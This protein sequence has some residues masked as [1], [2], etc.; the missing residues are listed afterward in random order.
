MAAMKDEGPRHAVAVG[1]RVFLRPPEEADRDAFRRLIAESQ[2]FLAPW[3]PKAATD[4]G[5]DHRFE[6]L[7][8]G[9]AKGGSYKH[10]A[11]HLTDGQV[12][13]CMN[14]NNVVRGVGQYASLGYW[15]GAPYA[16]QGFMTEALQLALLYA[17]EGLG[18]HRVE[19]N[20]RPANAASVALVRRAGFRLEGYS[21]QYLKIAGDWADHERY[22]L[23][24]AEWSRPAYARLAPN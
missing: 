21:P 10:F 18:L 13:G 2:A 23:L 1:E 7:V 24:V 8:A 5:P 22:A 11:C 6:R 17:F 9:N 15:I 12:M 14:V 3:E 4:A 16:R 20:V 19:A